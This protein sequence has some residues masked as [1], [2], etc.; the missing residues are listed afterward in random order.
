MI[1]EDV[2]ISSDE[3]DNNSIS[4]DQMSTQL[5]QFALDELLDRSNDSDSSDEDTVACVALP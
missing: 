1:G 3:V 5:E 4:S 2:S